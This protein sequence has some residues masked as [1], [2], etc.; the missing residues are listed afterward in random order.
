LDKIIK[1][2]SSL[3]IIVYIKLS[4]PPKIVL[5]VYFGVPG[6]QI[7]KGKLPKKKKK[8]TLEGSKFYLAVIV[9]KIV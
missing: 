9:I 2:S 8:V 6:I 1:R 4:M 7:H 3:L 5:L